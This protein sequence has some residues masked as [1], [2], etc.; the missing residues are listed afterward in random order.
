MTDTLDRKNF[1]LSVVIPVYNE[2]GTIAEI[3]ERVRATPFRKEII[4]VDD[5][6]TDRTR[7]ILA[8]LGE[9]IRAFYHEKNQV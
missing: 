2:E 7:E 6:S 9:H 1:L 4:V 3:L 8:G 5:C